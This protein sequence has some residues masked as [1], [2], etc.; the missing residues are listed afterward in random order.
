MKTK[1]LKNFTFILALLLILSFD[2]EP[3]PGWFKAGSKVKSYEMGIDKG[4]GMEG[5]NCA[6]IKSVEKKIEGFGTLMQSFN[7]DNYLGKKTRMTGF[8]KSENVK[9]WAGFWM[10]VDSKD[11]KKSLSFDNMADRPVKGT[12]DWKQYEIVLEVPENAGKIAFGALLTGTG[13]IWFDKIDFEIGDDSVETT[14]KKKTE[15]QNL[16]FE[17]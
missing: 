10:R 8:I 4:A 1:I 15:P 12:T 9:D 13:Q 16:N 2:F 7:P 3:A 5:K 17:D 11:I 14:G 6:S